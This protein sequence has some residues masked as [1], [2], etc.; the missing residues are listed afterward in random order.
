MNP[1]AY[2]TGL[3]LIALLVVAAAVTP[4]F[5]AHARTTRDHGPECWWCHPRVIRRR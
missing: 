5:L 1:I 3:V 4:L 2:A